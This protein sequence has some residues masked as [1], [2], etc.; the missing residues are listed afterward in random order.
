MTAFVEGASSKALR[1]RRF[2]EGASSKALRRRRFVKRPRAV[3]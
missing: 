2:V 3:R 1:R